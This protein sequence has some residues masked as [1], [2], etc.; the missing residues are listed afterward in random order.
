MDYLKVHRA[1]SIDGENTQSS[2]IQGICCISLQ[3]NKLKAGIPIKRSPLKQTLQ[4]N[5]L[6][7]S[8]CIKRSPSDQQGSG[9]VRGQGLPGQ[10]EQ[11]VS[12]KSTIV[13]KSQNWFV[14]FVNYLKSSKVLDDKV[15]N[16]DV[17][18]DWHRIGDSGK[19]HKKIIA[20]TYS[21]GSMSKWGTSKGSRGGMPRSG[22]PGC[23]ESIFQDD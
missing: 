2:P 19:D 3:K 7:A 16:C 10:D 14:I 13:I 20:Q 12:G 1:I 9:L 11:V 23:G 22:I 15:V 5:K 17:D 4:Q 6:K 8:T 21:I 18:I